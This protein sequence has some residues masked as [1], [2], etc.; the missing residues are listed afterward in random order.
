VAV[1]SQAT[2]SSNE[3]AK[4]DQRTKSTNMRP[5]IAFALEKLGLRGAVRNARDFLANEFGKFPLRL[6]IHFTPLRIVVGSGGVVQDGWTGTDKACL[7]LLDPDAWENFFGKQRI[8]A[9]LAEHV[10]EHLTLDEAVVAA[11]TCLRFLKPGGYLRIAVPDGNHPDRDYIRHVRPGG[12]GPGA[13][14]HKVLYNYE[15]LSR[16]L[17]EAGFAIKLL[18]YFDEEGRF[19]FNEWDAS[20]GMINR[21]SRYDERNRDGKLNYTSLIVDAYSS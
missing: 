15:L 10:W 21:S 16:T 19:V 3:E 8:D 18:E 13:D 20:D 12:S 1:I 17:S 7:D 5:L 2:V 9:I 4:P 6:A 11:K 14:D